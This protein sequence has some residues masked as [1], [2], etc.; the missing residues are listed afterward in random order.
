M[1]AYCVPCVFLNGLAPI[2]SPRAMQAERN[3]LIV[4][5]VADVGAPQPGDS[6]A[7]APV[8]RNRFGLDAEWPVIL[9]NVA[10]PPQ[11]Q[12]RQSAPGKDAGDMEKHPVEGIE[13]F[14][15]LFRSEE[16]TSEL[17][18]LMRISYDVFC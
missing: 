6:V 1:R 18:S 5:V 16:H 2:P 13:I 7:L 15:D 14:A 8:A 3:D 11:S 17:Q 4:A 10:D 9:G 12:P